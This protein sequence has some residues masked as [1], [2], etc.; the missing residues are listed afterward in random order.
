[1]KLNT[2]LSSFEKELEVRKGTFKESMLLEE[3]P[4]WTLRNHGIYFFGQQET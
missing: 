4:Q 3:I 2:F 1:M